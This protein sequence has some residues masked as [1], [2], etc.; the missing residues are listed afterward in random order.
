[1]VE[2][3]VMDATEAPPGDGGASMRGTGRGVPVSMVNA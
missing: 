1:M 2:A 3:M